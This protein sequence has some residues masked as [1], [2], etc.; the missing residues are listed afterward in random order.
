MKKISTL[1]AIC[2]ALSISSFAQWSGN[3]ND[4]NRG[5]RN[6]N[7]SRHGNNSYNR[8]YSFHSEADLLRDMNL[9]RQQERKIMRINEEYRDKA[10]RIQNNRFGAAQ[11]K[12]FQLERLEQQRKQEIMNV[13]SRFQR[14]RYNT[15]CAR[16]TNNSTYGNG[17]YGNGRW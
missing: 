11:Q 15:W 17:N 8:D 9:S 13:L 4:D 16:N 12:R 14:D 2:L 1:I 3:G 10:F 7:D 5:H 6:N